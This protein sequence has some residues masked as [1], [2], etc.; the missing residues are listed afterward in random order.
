MIG[1]FL[2]FYVFTSFPDSVS[3]RVHEWLDDQVR[4]HG[5]SFGR[6]TAGQLHMGGWD[7]LLR[8][9]RGII[10]SFPQIEVDK[11]EIRP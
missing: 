3:F 11:L 4:L 7:S 10:E 2:A 5:R 9:I 8:S 1:A 6:N